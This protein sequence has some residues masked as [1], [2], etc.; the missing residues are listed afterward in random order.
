MTSQP[1]PASALTDSASRTD[2]VQSP[3]K[4]T[5][6]SAFGLTLR[7]PSANA[8][9]VRS[10]SAIGLAAIYPS[11]LDLVERPAAT[12]F[13]SIHSCLQDSVLVTGRSS[14]QLRQRTGNS[15]R[16]S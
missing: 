10:T 13:T 11:L 14:W 1:A 8:L 9:I 15:R 3:V 7:A 4:T 12:P 5:W 2:S 16:R 6:T